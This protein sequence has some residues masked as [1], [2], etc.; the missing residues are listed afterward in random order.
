MEKHQ[1]AVSLRKVGFFAAMNVTRRTYPCAICG[2]EVKQSETLYWLTVLLGC[3][4]VPLY[5]GCL[6]LGLFVFHAGVLVS[7]LVPLALAI[8]AL[9]IRLLILRFGKWVEAQVSRCQGDGS[10][11][12]K[13]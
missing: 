9:A 7:N 1:H 4:P 13:K 10:R 8:S 3:L 6:L 12:L 2:K 5:F 11:P